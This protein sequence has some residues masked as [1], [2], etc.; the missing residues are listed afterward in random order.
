MQRGAQFK[1]HILRKG[2]EKPVAAYSPEKSLWSA[3]GRKRTL[4]SLFLPLQMLPCC[5]IDAVGWWPEFQDNSS[6]QKSPA[7]YFQRHPRQGQNTSGLRESDK[8][9]RPATETTNMQSTKRKIHSVFL[10]KEEEQPIH[11]FWSRLKMREHCMIL[12]WQKISNLAV[13]QSLQ[14]HDWAL[15]IKHTVH[16]PSQKSFQFQIRF[17]PGKCKYILSAGL[18]QKTAVPQMWNHK[19]RWWCLHGNW[20]EVDTHLSTKTTLVSL[21]S[22]SSWMKFLMKSDTDS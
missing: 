5:G 16:V 18:V 21:L 4:I 11:W 17:T 19:N 1:P 7:W 3:E 13:S 20:Q 22:A 8:P 10:G 14:V 2:S 15:D 6:W 9:V 12:V